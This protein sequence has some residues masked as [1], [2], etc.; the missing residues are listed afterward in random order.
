MEHGPLPWLIDAVSVKAKYG[1][2][3]GLCASGERAEDE[4]D[5]AFGVLTVGA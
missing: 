3:Q 5:G 1:H 4:G 2:H